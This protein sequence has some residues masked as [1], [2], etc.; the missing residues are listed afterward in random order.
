MALQCGQWQYCGFWFRQSLLGDR[1]CPVIEESSPAYS[2]SQQVGKLYWSKGAQF[3][4][5]TTI[6]I[7]CGIAGGLVPAGI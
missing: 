4:L 1:R 2:Y 5:S 6:I 3:K 7:C